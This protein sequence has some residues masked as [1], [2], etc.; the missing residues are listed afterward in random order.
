MLNCFEN[1]TSSSTEAGSSRIFSL[2]HQIWKIG[3]DFSKQLSIISASSVTSV[4]DSYELFTGK[5]SHVHYA[6]NKGTIHFANLSK[7]RLDV[8]FQVSD[9]GVAFRYYFPDKSPTIK[10]IQQNLP[11]IISILLQEHFCSP[12]KKPKSGWE[13]KS[14]LTKKIM[15]RICQ[16]VLLHLQARMGIS[17]IISCKRWM[18]THYRSIH[19]WNLLRIPGLLQRGIW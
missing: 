3:P 5:K 2:R 4:T 11:A 15:F 10:K 9:D 1:L 16:L 17:G 12:C 14:S 19:G 6:A 18:G 8:I 7:K 13:N